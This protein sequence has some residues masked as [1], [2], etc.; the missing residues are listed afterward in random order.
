MKRAHG[1]LPTTLD[2]RCLEANPQKWRARFPAAVPTPSNYQK[3]H[4]LQIGCWRKWK[5]R[6][7]PKGEETIIALLTIARLIS[8]SRYTVPAF[9]RNVL[10]CPGA[11][12]VFSAK[13][14]CGFAA[15]CRMRHGL[16]SLIAWKQL[17][18]F[19]PPPDIKPAG[20]SHQ[21]VTLPP[22]AL[23]DAKTHFILYLASPLHRCILHGC[24]ATTPT[25]SA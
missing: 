23:Q 12:Y 6:K 11:S 5:K 19:P 15:I 16:V 13:C 21:F 7:A 8:N 18:A 24:G 22:R 1:P 17:G 3:T 20:T 10:L 2:Q 14:R 4:S 25:L 9:S